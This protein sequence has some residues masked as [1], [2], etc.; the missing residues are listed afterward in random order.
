MI[1]S[2]SL[3]EYHWASN[4]LHFK[5]LEILNQYYNLWQIESRNFDHFLLRGVSFLLFNLFRLIFMNSASCCL[6]I[7]FLLH[8][9]SDLVIMAFRYFFYILAEA[10]WIK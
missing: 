3:F 10:K 6:T 1:I 2:F 7:L 8:C 4:N 5:S 9:E